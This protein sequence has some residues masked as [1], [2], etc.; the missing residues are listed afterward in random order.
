MT[1]TP[2]RPVATALQLKDKL[3][4]ARKKAVFAR[5]I[6]NTAFVSAD[7]ALASLLSAFHILAQIVSLAPKIADPKATDIIHEEL[8]RI[9]GLHK[10]YVEGN[11]SGFTKKDLASVVGQ[12]HRITVD[13]ERNRLR[14]FASRR[15]RVF[16]KVSF[17]LAVSALVILFCLLAVGLVAAW[18]YPRYDQGLTATYFAGPRFDGASFQV[19]DH[20]VDF[21]WNKKAPMAKMPKNNFSVRWEGCVRV[22]FEGGRYLAASADD[23]VVVIVDGETEIDTRGVGVTDEVR[24]SN[25]KIGPGLHPIEIQ[26]REKGGNAHVSLRWAAH[27]QKSVVIPADSL[28]PRFLVMGG[29]GSNPNCPPMPAPKTLPP[30]GA[31]KK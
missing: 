20:R 26:Y 16:H 5:S 31:P 3:A 17:A 25:H 1:D 9:A 27:K 23:D 22:D 18:R 28:V 10:K 30:G 15:E 12:I 21:H 2:H 7:E 29:F 6:Y 14:L 24:F 4:S 11:H 8:T 19:V 13:I